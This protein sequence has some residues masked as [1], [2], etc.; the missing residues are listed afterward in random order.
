ML[1]QKTVFVDESE[2]V[3]Q[4]DHFLECVAHKSVLPCNP[5]NDDATLYDLVADE[6]LKLIDEQLRFYSM[7]RS[8]V[9]G[10]IFCRKVDEA[11]KLSEKLNVLGYKTVALSGLNSD[12]ERRQAIHRLEADDKSP[13]SVN[14]IIS[15]DIFNEGIDIPSVNQPRVFKLLVICCYNRNLLIKL[16]KLPL[17]LAINEHIDL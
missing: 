4:T 1:I 6:R 11:A 8:N 7:G 9:K 10:L 2:N 5:A 13:D 3:S 17:I 14:Y 16:R 15:V 12:E